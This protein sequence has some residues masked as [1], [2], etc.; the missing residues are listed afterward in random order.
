MQQTSS[1]VRWNRQVGPD[2]YQIGLD[3]PKGYHNTQPGQ[4]VMVHL[5][6]QIAPLLARPFSIFRL[7]RHARQTQGIELLYKV[8]GEGT[9]RMAS[10]VPG[11]HLDVLGPLGQGFRITA[12]WHKVYI[13]AGGIG[14]APMVFLAEVLKPSRGERR[15]Q[16][17]FLGGRSQGDLLCADAFQSMGIPVHISTDDGSAGTQG[18]VTQ[19]LQTR[20]LSD[21]PDVI[22]ACGPMAML[23]GVA[24]I[25]ADHGIACQVSLETIMA[26]GMGACLGCAFESR[27]P[28]GRYRHVCLDGPVFDA[29]QIRL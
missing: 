5:P 26:C 13:V 18:L 20:L 6:G 3:C 11:E 17:V 7:I 15:Q 8:V 27:M 19:P 1:R 4:F 22:L 9:R 14:V 28:D 29:A 24:K 12:D 10:L 2:V 16:Q 21:T 23:K 25:A